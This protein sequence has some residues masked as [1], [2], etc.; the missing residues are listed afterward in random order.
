MNRII[1][2]LY[3]KR[4]RVFHIHIGENQR[5][6]RITGFLPHQR[7]G[8]REGNAMCADTVLCKYLHAEKAAPCKVGNVPFRVRAVELHVHANRNRRFPVQ[9]VDKHRHRR[10]RHIVRFAL[11]GNI[12][13]ILDNSGGRAAFLQRIQVRFGSA[14]NTLEV[15]AIAGRAGQ[16][17]QVHHPNH[18]LFP[19]EQRLKRRLLHMSLASFIFSIS[20]SEYPSSP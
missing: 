18:R 4:K 17:K 10:N 15:S 9:A 14:V 3:G 8:R 1:K 6:R 19:A 13:K 11:V 20:L 7:P 16:C 5:T 2:R 12:P